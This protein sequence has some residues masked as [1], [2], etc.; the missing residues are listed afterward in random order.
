MPKIKI[1]RHLMYSKTCCYPYFLQAKCLYDESYWNVEFVDYSSYHR[2]PT[3]WLKWSCY[4][5]LKKNQSVYW[6]QMWCLA[7][8]G[9][10]MS[11]GLLSIFF[12]QICLIW[13]NFFFCNKNGLLG[14]FP[15]SIFANAYEFL[16]L[17]LSLK[18]YLL[19]NG[20]F[21][22][23]FALELI[24]PILM[25]VFIMDKKYSKGFNKF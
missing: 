3:F 1:W 13:N 2:G 15:H 22:K 7:T 8:F 10:K 16:T 12:A 25:H 9:T 5:I 24:T 20:Y 11:H 21:L 14:H 4:S 6:T 18:K 19:R 23:Y 17:F